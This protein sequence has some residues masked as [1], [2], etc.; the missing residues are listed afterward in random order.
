ME[1]NKL[2][3]EWAAEMAEEEADRRRKAEPAPELDH[4]EFLAWRSPRTVSESPTCLD[5][6]LWH[7]L[8]RTRH[9]AYSA[10]EAFHG[11]SPFDAGPMWCFDRFGKSETALRDGRVVHI[12]GEHEDYYDPDFFI[13]NDITVVGPD[14]SIAIYGYSREVLPPTDF[15]SAT[16]V[17]DAIIIIGCLG[18]PR[19]R[20]LGSTPVFRLALD[21]MRISHVET[22]GEPPGWIHKHSAAPAEDGS[23]VV[24]QGGEIW[25]GED[26]TMKENI[27]TWSL[28][29]AS[30]RWVRLSSL[31]WQRWTMRRVD[32]K[33]NRLWDARQALWHR[34]HAW[35]GL[36]N[37]WN[38]ADAPDFGALA[39]LYRLDETTPAPER[40][41][42]HNVFRVVVDGVSVRF[43]EDGWSVQAIVEGR[44][45]EARLMALQSKTLATLQQLD[46]SAWEIEAP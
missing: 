28:D 11:P 36:E 35:A 38:H 32:R 18:Y 24:V 21:T 5:N 29:I 25:M 13:Y 33:R 42:G 15:H 22:S 41:S 3:P 4:A 46:A 27:D 12:G 37:R 17:G 26:R 30:G 2:D 19:Q 39:E 31:D 34:D 7:W 45:S 6:P 43:T 1:D 16:L 10:N 20:V 40:G 14:G 9:S 8:V 44:L 23:S